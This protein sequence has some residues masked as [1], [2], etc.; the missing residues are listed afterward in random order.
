MDAKSIYERKIKTQLTKWKTRVEELKT[1]VE[2]AGTD[3]RSKYDEFLPTLHA[4]REVAEKKLEELK[5]ASGATWESV[6]TGV[7]HAWSDLSAATENAIT[8]FRQSLSSPNRDEEIHLIAYGIWDS[9]GRPEGRDREHWLRAESIWQ[10][11]QDL[12]QAQTGKKPKRA[13]RKKTT[14]AKPAGGDAPPINED[15]AGEAK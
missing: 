15:D 4:K 11:R 9:E 10:E 12:I 8:K 7:E 14:A 6:K 2:K 13:A 1:H 3:A 5:S